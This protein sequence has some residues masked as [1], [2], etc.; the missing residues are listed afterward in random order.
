M[1]LFTVGP[2]MMRKETL[3]ESLHQLPYAR[4]AQFSNIM[5]DV[6]RMLKQ[7]VDA[8]EEDK[9]FILTGSGTCGMEAVVASSFDEHDHVLIIDG[10][11]FGERFV[12]LC[13]IYHVPYTKLSLKFQEAL[14]KEH[15]QKYDKEQFSA[16]L[17]NVHETST[18][19]LYDLSILKEFA[20]AKRIPLVVDAISAVLAD[21]IRMQQDDID[22]LIMSSQKAFALAPGLS[23][24][25]MTASFFQ[26]YVAEK[27]PK[28]MYLDLKAYEQNMKRGQTPFTPA[29]GIVMTLWQR[30]QQIIQDGVKKEQDSIKERALYFRKL[31]KQHGLCVPE[32]YPLS[33]ALTPIYFADG[34]AKELYQY[35]VDK[36]EC[37][38]TPSGGALADYLIRVGHIGELELQDYDELMDAIL[39]FYKGRKKKRKMILMA[40]GMGT[41]ISNITNGPKSLL[42][43]GEE[44]LLEH[45]VKLLMHNDFEVHVVL[46]YEGRQIRECLKNYPVVFH[47]NPFY[48]STNSIASLWFVKEE[49]LS[50]DDI[51]LANADVYWE[52]DMLDQ[53]LACEK[54]VMMLMDERRKMCGDYFFGCENGVLRHYGKD[55]PEH[56]RSGEYVGIAKVKSTFV[57][58]LYEQLLYLVESGEYQK[59]WE[60][61]LYTLLDKECIH[62]EDVCGKFWSEIDVYED[63]LRI[64]SYKQSFHNKG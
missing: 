34:C 41:R 24:I 42:K 20:R 45:T 4:T 57:E 36:K 38:V 60:D 58:K 17:V 8:K 39:A 12:E 31:C 10:G 47:E 55:L 40:A 26:N 15:L 11:S 1:K 29:V 27:K 13:E 54:D 62:V 21:D 35:L 56:L 22:V 7:I 33:N 19:Q 32:E 2:V 25:V 14:T 43:I 3:L 44:P 6:E 23:M 48:R 59:W 18:G 49:L 64:L 53:L 9:T 30:L 28:T 37:Y 63:Y 50:G 61:A 51:Y 16:I 52:Q 5:K 46:G